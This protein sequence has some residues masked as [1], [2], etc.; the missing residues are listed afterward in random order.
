MALTSWLTRAS[1]AAMAAARGGK[2][3]G[4]DHRYCIDNGGMIAQAGLLAFQ[5]GY[6][7]PLEECTCT[8]RFR[9]D[10]VDVTWRDAR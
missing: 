8:Q 1:M 3:F 5:A 6:V 4:M 10:E 7:T 9:T 2:L